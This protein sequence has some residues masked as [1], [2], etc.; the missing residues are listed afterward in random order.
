MLVLTGTASVTD[1]D[2]ALKSITFSTTNSTLG[3]RTIGWTVTD[4][5]PSNGIGTATS[6][7]AVVQGLTVAATGTVTFDGGGLPVTLDNSVVVFDP[8]NPPNS[9][10]L[11][12]ATVAIA[13]AIGGDTLNFTPAIGADI[14]DIT[15]TSEDSGQQLLFTSSGSATVAEWDTALQ[16]I[17]YSFNPSDGDPS[18]GGLHP[19]R[20]IDWSITD[21]TTVSTT[22]TS[23][24]DTVHTPPAVTV[25][26]PSVAFTGGSTTPVTLDGGIMVGDVDSSGMLES[27]TVT[28]GSTFFT[29]DTLG[30]AINST[31]TGIT[32][33]AAGNYTL[34]FADNS[35]LSAFYN[36]AT[37][38]LTLTG[39]DAIGDYQAALEA[40]TYSFTRAATIPPKTAPI[41]AAPSLGRS[42]TGS[43]PAPP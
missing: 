1:Y 30:F 24:V 10:D 38:E 14:G 32:G 11:V 2:A 33:P 5:S 22:A 12:S 21:N 17:T 36:S 16:S 15:A 20:T 4:G 37:G 26:T 43:P 28:I 13:N 25:G 40:V 6:T 35:T 9:T 8:V 34:S 19:S 39:T 27:A 7:V 18:G 29:G 23:I 41:L 42:A 31:L 3:D